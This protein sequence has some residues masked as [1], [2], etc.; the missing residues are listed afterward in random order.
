MQEKELVIKGALII[1]GDG[2]IYQGKEVKISGDRVSEIGENI[3]AEGAEILH[4]PNCILTP[5]LINLHCHSPMGLMRGLGEDLKIEDWFNQFIWRFETRLE[6]PDVK[7]GA[8]LGISEML[9]NG[10]TAFADH[11]FFAEQ[12][13]EAAEESGIRAD[14][15]PTIFGFG[16]KVDE[17]IEEAARLIE[18]WKRK[19]GSVTMR[20]GPHAP[21]TCPPEVL[22]K[23][24]RWAE[25]LGVGSH[26][27]VS[28]TLD[29]VEESKKQYGKTPFVILKE[30]GLLEQHIIIG[31][32]LWIEEE[33]IDLLPAEAYF[34]AS[35]KTYMK[36]AMGY[37]NLWKFADRLQIAT[38]TDGAASSS[39]LSPLEQ[40]RLFALIGKQNY[41]A[42]CFT[43]EEI[44][45]ILMMGHQALGQKSGLIRPGYLADLVVWD[46]G[47]P[48]TWPVYNP[49][50][51]LLYSAD[52]S[53]V[54]DVIV[55][56]EL[57]LKEKNLTRLKE[58][59][60]LEMVQEAVNR[61]DS[62]EEGERFARY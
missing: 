54:R 43:L 12:I 61:I 42:E 23:V 9:K 38:G 46:I 21:Y 16:D 11:Y 48:S 28:E 14:I 52:S 51:S 60:I 22:K 15:A 41:G 56:G 17:N 2:Q 31:H 62:R 24:S 32:G 25:Q 50:S 7:V 18:T 40:A 33:E 10:V 26:I 45:K 36:L 1:D 3:E 55:D 13:A 19:K 59:D 5:G 44:W 34:A 49:L 39:S 29:Q 30:A 37:G 4:R 8:F 58:E 47:C 57:V 35:P 20:M 53:N 27:H 6:A